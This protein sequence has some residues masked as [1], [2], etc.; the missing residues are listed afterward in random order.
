MAKR[1]QKRSGELTTPQ[2][3]QPQFQVQ[4]RPVDTAIKPNVAGAPA[5]P[6]M[7]SDPARPDFQRADDLNRLGKSLMGLSTT[8]NSLIKL[9]AIRTDEA[10]QDALDLMEE[11]DKSL[12]Q[13]QEEG[14]LKG[15]TPAHN[16]GYARA[17]STRRL[18][19]EEE[20]Y[21]AG[22]P[23]MRTEAGAVDPEYAERYMRRRAD[24]IRRQIKDSG[25]HEGHF[26][27]AFNKGFA[28]LL[29]KINRRHHAWAGD[30]LQKR[31]AG[32]VAAELQ[33][34]AQTIELDGT[35]G[36]QTRFDQ[37][38]QELIDGRAEGR[39]TQRAAH[40][41]VGQ[42]AVDLQIAYPEL[43]D[44]MD[45][46]L[47]TIP[48]GPKSRSQFGPPDRETKRNGRL[49]KIS[50]VKNYRAKKQS[51]IDEGA[52][53]LAR[54]EAKLAFQTDMGTLSSQL[55]VAAGEY[56][57]DHPDGD[58]DRFLAETGQFGFAAVMS[59]LE[60]QDPDFALE[61]TTKI[62]NGEMSYSPAALDSKTAFTFTDN[63][64]GEDTTIDVT[65]ML[66][67]ASRI[68]SDA[69]L[70]ASQSAGESRPD[71]LASESRQLGRIHPEAKGAIVDGVQNLFTGADSLLQ[72]MSDEGFDIDQSPGFAGFLRG[73]EQ[74]RS[75]G[76]D[77]TVL[78]QEGLA[79]EVFVYNA[80]DFL[81]NR[82]GNPLEPQAAYVQLVRSLASIEDAGEYREGLSKAIDRQLTID[83]K[84]Y[85]GPLIKKTALMMSAFS[86]DTLSGGLY[87]DAS[88]TPS[89]AVKD[90]VA[91]SSAYVEKNS[92]FIGGRAFEKHRLPPDF[93][94]EEGTGYGDLLRSLMGG[95]PRDVINSQLF[96][97]IRGGGGGEKWQQ[98]MADARVAEG[99]TLGRVEPTDSTFTSFLLYM[100]PP[101]DLQQQ[102]EMGGFVLNPE[103]PVDGGYSITELFGLVGMDV[104]GIT[105]PTEEEQAEIDKET[106]VSTARQR[107]I[108]LSM[109]FS[110]TPEGRQLSQFGGVIIARDDELGEQLV[111]DFLTRNPSM[112]VLLDPDSNFVL[113]PDLDKDEFERRK[114]LS[115][116][117]LP[118]SPMVGMVLRNPD[119]IRM[120]MSMPDNIKEA[121]PELAWLDDPTQEIPEAYR[122]GRNPNDAG[123][124][125]GNVSS[126]TG[127]E[128]NKFIPGSVMRVVER[129]GDA[130]S[131]VDEDY[132]VEAIQSAYSGGTPNEKTKLLLRLMEA[133]PEGLA[134]ITKARESRRTRYNLTSMVMDDS[135]MSA[136]ETVRAYEA[137]TLD[138]RSTLGTRFEQL[139]DA[140]E[141]VIGVEMSDEDRKIVDDL[142]AEVLG[143]TK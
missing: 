33:R 1:P 75:F 107:A 112:Q 11:T 10:Q 138:E 50:E 91:R 125:F 55:E 29:N 12:A 27:K 61:L 96:K 3:Q 118:S 59:I 82:V 99:F 44:A 24:E 108:G 78:S 126:V 68:S 67:I 79:D 40:L 26:N 45:R 115:S 66:Q 100:I 89:Q 4:A 98:W 43:K 34:I 47:D 70:N 87:L 113:N 93:N 129:V 71:A 128:M 18:L 64:T 136:P 48:I 83:Q 51:Q 46:V 94:T 62:K 15:V 110:A 142:V 86:Q 137:M 140:R 53:R 14:K 54:N 39:L 131:K 37:E 77:Q 19:E 85:L 111:Q 105:T 38:I 88:N 92:V 8:V 101:Y 25:I 32:D 5:K 103:N 104:P 21:L 30:E 69:R 7:E 84:T 133:S 42:A 95:H 116:G 57:R 6:L 58:V 2:L 72:Q 121:L 122:M 63:K 114:K 134:A 124:L 13:L 36:Q 16:R 41:I 65:K 73:Y 141:M 109:L 117:M 143:R 132:T 119:T 74:F 23:Q 120:W 60:E 35:D 130:L 17:E 139:R 97:A 76:V 81:R 20:K 123:S 31:T 80:Y 52:A 49:S 135:W 22:E 56:L 28:E 106:A 102:G 127:E 90:L 9:E